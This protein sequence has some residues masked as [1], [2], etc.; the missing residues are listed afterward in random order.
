MTVLSNLKIKYQTLNN[1]KTRLFI[2]K[3]NSVFLCQQFYK[4]A[5][6]WLFGKCCIVIL[7]EWV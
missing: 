1:A 6:K 7:C 3:C 4:A 5:H 2:E